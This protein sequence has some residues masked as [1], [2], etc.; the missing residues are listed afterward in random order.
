MLKNVVRCP[1]CRG[2][3]DTLLRKKKI[4]SEPSN[5]SPVIIFCT[6]C[7]RSTVFAGIGGV[8]VY[9][10]YFLFTLDKDNNSTDTSRFL[11]H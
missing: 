3:N 6:D 1:H 4:L 10:W 11:N 7:A 5:K 9:F 2:K 8:F